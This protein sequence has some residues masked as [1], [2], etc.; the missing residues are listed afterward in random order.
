MKSYCRIPAIAV[1]LFLCGVVFP[2][3]IFSQEG[4]KL[5]R[6]VFP[7]PTASALAKYADIPVSLYT[8]TA[9]ISVPLY[10]L[11]SKTLSLPISLSYHSGGIKVQEAGGW[12][13]MGW[14]LNSG[15][16]ITRTVRG[17]RYYKPVDLTPYL[18]KLITGGIS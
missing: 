2:L 16:V 12:V 6:T 17:L 15:G 10:E 3:T 1:Q 11:K 8:G 13:G 4:Y 9:N 5:P 14:S 18:Q 7:S